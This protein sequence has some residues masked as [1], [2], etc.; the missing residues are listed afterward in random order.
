LCDEALIV[1]VVNML[2]LCC[3]WNSSKSIN[4]QDQVALVRLL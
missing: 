1:T 2:Y 3:T 4:I